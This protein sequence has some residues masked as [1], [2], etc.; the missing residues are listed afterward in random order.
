MTSPNSYRFSKLT[1]KDLPA[2]TAWQSNSHVRKWWDASEPY[3]EKDLA[4][5]RVSR[6][7]VSYKE[8]PF[9]FMQDYSVHGWEDHHFA[10]LPEG[11]RGIDQF[12]GEP[13]MQGQGHGT[14]FISQR[15]HDL[16][17]AGVPLIA[18]DPHPK[19]A[20]A[21]AVYTK[22]G[23]RASGAAM[24]TQWGFILPMVAKRTD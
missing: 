10:N 23:F 5:T 12:I 8:R 21:I 15:M 17:S 2:L 18:T 3:D 9:A 14:A 1:S 19:N 22:L 11:T 16:F 7:I 4:D 6:W 24:E 13:D 20:R